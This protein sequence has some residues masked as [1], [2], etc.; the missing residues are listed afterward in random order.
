MP[1]EEC[2][3]PCQRN[4]AD[5][6]LDR[7][8]IELDAAISKDANETIPVIEAVPD[9]LGEGRSPGDSGKARL[10]P[11]LQILDDGLRAR[12]PLGTAH[13][14]GAT[15]DLCLDRIQLVNAHE[16]VGRDRR[17]TAYRDLVEPPSQVTPA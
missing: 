2:I 11:Q 5:L 14:R 4:R 3:L 1:G 17:I 16:R 6:A 10:Q 7:I 8:G 13:L 9:V 15:A 12:L